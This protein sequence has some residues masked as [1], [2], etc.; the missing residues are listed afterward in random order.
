M[1]HCPFRSHTRS[2]PEESLH[3]ALLRPATRGEIVLPPLAHCIGRHPGKV[4]GSAVLL[5]LIGVCLQPVFFR[6]SRQRRVPVPSWRGGEA[7]QCS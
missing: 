6:A 2:F 7:L 1:E 4:E 5:I 3:G